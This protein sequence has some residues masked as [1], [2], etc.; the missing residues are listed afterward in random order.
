VNG[1]ALRALV[2]H[3]HS[4]TSLC[5]DNLARV[6]AVLQRIRVAELNRDK[7]TGARIAV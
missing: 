3:D 4:V 5:A 6:A 2:T 7:P 1:K